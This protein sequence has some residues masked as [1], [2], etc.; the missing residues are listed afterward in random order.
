MLQNLF[1]SLFSCRHP[2][3]RRSWPITLRERTYCV[4]TECGHE[5]PFDSDAFRMLTRGEIRRLKQ[6]A[7]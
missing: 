5:F 2:N 6:R 7:R 3:N 4:C 1:R